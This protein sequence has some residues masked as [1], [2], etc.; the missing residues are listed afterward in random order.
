MIA[1]DTSALVAI[2]LDEPE[3]VAF[4]KVIRDASNALIST[5]SVVEAKMVLYGRKGHRAV[6][7][8]DDLP[9]LPRFEVAPPSVADH[10]CRIRCVSDFWLRYRSPRKVKLRRWVSY[11]L[12]KVRNLSLLYKGNAFAETDLHPPSRASQVDPKL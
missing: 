12:A 1:V 5:V 2:G 7:I 6:V 8:L 11:A 9:H 4:L 10:G 3:R